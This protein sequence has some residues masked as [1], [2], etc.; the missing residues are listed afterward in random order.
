MTRWLREFPIKTKPY[1]VDHMA[2][3]RDMISNRREHKETQDA[4]EKEISLLLRGPSKKV[5]MAPSGNASN[6]YALKLVIDAV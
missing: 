4:I 5:L 6:P 1:Y 2:P 3:F